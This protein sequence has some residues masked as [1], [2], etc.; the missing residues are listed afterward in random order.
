MAATTF[1]DISDSAAISGVFDVVSS[2]RSLSI[3]HIFRYDFHL[4]NGISYLLKFSYLL[5]P[6]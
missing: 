2:L 4:D 1:N 3:P 5:A 6:R